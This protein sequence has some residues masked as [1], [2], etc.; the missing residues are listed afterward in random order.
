MMWP[1]WFSP[2]EDGIPL[3]LDVF[4]D[5]VYFTTLH[6]NTVNR[7]NKFGNPNNGVMPIFQHPLKVTDVLI[8]QE[9]KQDPTSELC[10]L[11]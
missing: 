7:I 3:S 8:V 6:T 9:Q 1:W 5:F 10:T 4:E 11:R 2:S